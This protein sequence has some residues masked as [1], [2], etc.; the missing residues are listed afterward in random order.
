M[1]PLTLLTTF[2]LFLRAFSFVPSSP[3][4]TFNQIL[5]AR[6]LRK[7]IPFHYNRRSIR[8]DARNRVVTSLLN[9][10]VPPESVIKSIE[11]SGYV[12]SA[13]D[14]ASAAGCDLNTAK[15]ALVQV[16]GMTG[17]DLKVSDDGDITYKFDSD[18][19]EKMNRNSFKAKVRGTTLAA[20][21]TPAPQLTCH[22]RCDQTNTAARLVLQFQQIPN[23][24]LREGGVRSDADSEPRR[25]V[26]CA[27]RH[28]QQ[29]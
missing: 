25:G 16:G 15:R 28:K 22:S 7:S 4:I 2:V 18:F 1:P 5:P 11:S 21:D 27:R 26:H 8:L 29:L 19:R 20:M 23:P 12:L 14:L 10:E 13:P 6:S 3:T 9:D 24:T 17:A